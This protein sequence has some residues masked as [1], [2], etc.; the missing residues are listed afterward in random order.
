MC[1]IPISYSIVVI[2][3][4]V[5]FKLKGYLVSLPGVAGGPQSALGLA[6]L[7]STY[8]H[9]NIPYDTSGSLYSIMQP[10]HLSDHADHAEDPF[11]FN[12]SAHLYTKLTVQYIRPN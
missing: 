1:I 11:R 2:F 7:L 6:G 4:P 5:V 12:V 9:D 8:R 3:L 10:P